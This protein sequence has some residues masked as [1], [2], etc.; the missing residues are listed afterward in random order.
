MQDIH[1]FIPQLSCTAIAT[2]LH[3]CCPR[4]SAAAYLLFGAEKEKGDVRAKEQS[5]EVAAVHP[6][7]H[8]LADTSTGSTNT[9]CTERGQTEMISAEPVIC[10]TQSSNEEEITAK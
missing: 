1:R 3:V 2:Q 5:K 6:A 10:K 4:C 7:S 8:A 9:A